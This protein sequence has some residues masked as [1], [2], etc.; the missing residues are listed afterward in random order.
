LIHNHFY[1]IG[2]FESH[3]INIKWKSQNKESRKLFFT[4]KQQITGISIFYFKE[5]RHSFGTER[6][7]NTK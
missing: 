6:V 7:S 3:A 4:V 2:I 1:Q 5:Y